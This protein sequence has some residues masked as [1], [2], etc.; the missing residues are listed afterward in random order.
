MGAYVLPVLVCADVQAVGGEGS[1]LMCN[2]QYDAGIG[3]GRVQCGTMVVGRNVWR[4]FSFCG[5]ASTAGADTF[6]WDGRLAA[7]LR[8]VAGLVSSRLISYYEYK[9]MI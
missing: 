8:R 1:T 4:C 9:S 3:L 6:A 2:K 5:T 7:A